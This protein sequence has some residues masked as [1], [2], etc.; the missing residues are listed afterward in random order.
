MQSTKEQLTP[1]SLNRGKIENMINVTEL[2]IGNVVV[3]NNEKYHPKSHG[4]LHSVLGMKYAPTKIAHEYGDYSLELECLVDNEYKDT[5]SQY[6]C[7]IDPIPLTEDILLKCGFYVDK[8]KAHIVAF[9]N[10]GIFGMNRI[11]ETFEFT[12]YATPILHLH[13]LQNLYFAVTKKELQINI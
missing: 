3:L 5:I 11:N 9:D 6:N 10:G 12:S 4:K 8:T 7:F 2:R 1:T 13:E